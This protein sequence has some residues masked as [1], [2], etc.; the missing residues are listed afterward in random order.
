MLAHD[1]A[2]KWIEIR[3]HNRLVQI[4]HSEMTVLANQLSPDRNGPVQPYLQQLG[5][6]AKMIDSTI[7]AVAN[8]HT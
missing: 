4:H 7:D 2:M 1:E 6:V 8:D 5:N 3:K